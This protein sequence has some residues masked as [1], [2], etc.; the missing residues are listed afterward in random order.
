MKNI[1]DR[2]LTSASLCLFK[3]I[4]ID[5]RAMDIELSMGMAGV[6]DLATEN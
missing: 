5:A 6:S 2:T 4:S 1:E 3:T